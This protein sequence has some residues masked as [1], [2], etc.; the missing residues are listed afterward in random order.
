M[1]INI[2][3]DA[4]DLFDIGAVEKAVR[5][6]IEETANDVEMTAKNLV[7]VDTGALRNSIELKLSELT[8]VRE[9]MEL[10][11]NM[12]A[13]L[14]KDEEKLLNEYNELLELA[15]EKEIEEFPTID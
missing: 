3:I 15:R 7:P 8:R 1:K 6:E 11:D 14:V 13:Q 2:H 5:D 4:T 9:S 12:K 10:L